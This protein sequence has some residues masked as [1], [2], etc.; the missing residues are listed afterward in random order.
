MGAWFNTLSGTDTG[1]SY[2]HP[3]YAAEALLRYGRWGASVEGAWLDPGADGS[4]PL[5][6]YQPGT[7]LLD[8]LLHYGSRTTELLAGYRVLTQHGADFLLVGAGFEH[9]AGPLALRG[10]GLVGGSTSLGY[11]FDLRGGLGWG[12]LEL[13]YRGLVI[14]R[15]MAGEPAYQTAGPYLTLAF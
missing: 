2:A 13:G 12:P 15:A 7:W 6:F 1:F 14:S 8:G 5:R 4:V 3:S 9:P 10:R 11:T